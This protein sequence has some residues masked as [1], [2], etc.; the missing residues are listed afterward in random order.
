MYAFYLPFNKIRN[1]LFWST[2]IS[3]EPCHWWTTL[4]YW[5][6]QGTLSGT[7]GSRLQL[8]TSITHSKWCSGSCST[9]VHRG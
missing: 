5:G 9:A 3:S 2:A 6:L 4:F 1:S 7:L 8:Q